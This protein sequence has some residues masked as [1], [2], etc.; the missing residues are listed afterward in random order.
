MLQLHVRSAPFWHN[1][2]LLLTV[3]NALDADYDD[4]GI[5]QADGLRFAPLL[6]QD[7]RSGWLGVE[8][9]L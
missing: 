9:Q 8:W 1:A 7:G 3:H 5:K 2:R 6:P 4:P